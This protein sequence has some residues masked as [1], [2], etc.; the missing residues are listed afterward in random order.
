MMETAE[1]GI[2]I[3]TD[4]GVKRF[5]ETELISKNRLRSI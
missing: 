5:W 3:T 4:Q 1:Y 2:E